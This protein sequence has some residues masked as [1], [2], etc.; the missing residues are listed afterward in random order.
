[1]HDAL[2]LLLLMLS[3][4]YERRGDNDM[5]RAG[6]SDTVAGRAGRGRSTV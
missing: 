4:F 1:M 5:G 3:E 2:L 6:H